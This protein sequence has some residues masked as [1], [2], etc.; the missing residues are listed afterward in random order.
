MTFFRPG[1][2]SIPTK[3]WDFYGEY[4]INTLTTLRPDGRPHVVPVG[5]TLDPEQGCA[6]IITRAGSRKVRNIEAAVAAGEPGALVAACQFAGPKWST[7]EGRAR[8]LTDQPSVERAI[9][10]YTAR[11]R[12]PAQNDH[13]RVA[14]R[15]EVDRIVHGPALVETPSA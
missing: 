15:I 12:M 8:V 3:L 6:W 5:V 9:A 7:I 1:W 10:L 4:L 13:T 14:I 2:D 11:Y